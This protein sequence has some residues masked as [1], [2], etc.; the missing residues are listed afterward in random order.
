MSKRLS[1]IHPGEILNEEFIAPRDLSAN[2]VALAL[3]IPA[4]R[5]SEIVRGRRSISADTAL[6]LARYFDTSP[7]LWLNLQMH[8][9]LEIAQDSM[10]EQIAREVPVGFRTP[11]RQAR[12][13]K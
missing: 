12:R 10:A 2:K 8:Y 5:L 11:K 1:P 3:R 6:R 7:E 13:K 9:D 4:N